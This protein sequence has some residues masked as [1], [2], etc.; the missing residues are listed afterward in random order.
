MNVLS[1]KILQLEESATLAMAR[2]SRELSSK[3]YSIINLSLG[4]PDFNTPNFIKKAAKIAI[5]DNYSKYTPV[6]GYTDLLNV[7]S[8]KFKRDNNLSYS[9]EQIVC[10]TGAK[11]SIAQL[12]MVLLN[13][14]EEVI[15]PT[16][17][18]VSYEQMI[19]LADG[20]IN[21]IQTEIENNFKITPKQL[22]S[23]ISDKT[24]IFLFSSPC[25]P[26]GSVYSKSELNALA[27][28][29][30]KY[31]HIIII[32]D[33]IYE[34]INFMDQHI[35]IGSIKGLENQVVT[36]NGLSKGYA[37]TGWRFGYIGAPEFIAKACVKM[38]GQLT[39]ATCSITQR[40]A[41]SALSED[42]SCTYEMK[43]E[44]KLRRNL[45]V[46]LLSNN[47]RMRLN[48]PDG[49]FYLFPDVSGYFETKYKNYK[50]TNSTDLAIFLLEDAGVS[51][52]AGSAFGNDKCIRISYAASRDQLKKASDKLNESLN[53][54][55]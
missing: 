23:S 12:L 46:D 43:Q 3:G 1:N 24:K 48:K 15:L 52:V 41:I 13:K 53:K 47:H 29:F 9:N 22:E 6:P 8:N 39:S 38:Q 19:T 18:W 44:F 16:P 2:K 30:K 40:A 20:K 34:H 5:D 21:R 55:H 7:I 35:S 27:Q 54:L 14:G 26:T 17:Y 50:I 11:Q 10:S 36:V 37:M 45:L 25:N 31:P 4:E 33:E 28:V 32:S 42:P 51:T 49:A